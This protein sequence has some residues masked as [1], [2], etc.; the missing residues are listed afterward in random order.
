MTWG[1]IEGTPLLI[2]SGSETPGKYILFDAMWG[3]G[4]RSCIY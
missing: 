1:D 2:A 4:G 3:A